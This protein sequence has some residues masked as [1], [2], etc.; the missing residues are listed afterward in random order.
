MDFAE[1]VIL[2]AR[3]KTDQLRRARPDAVAARRWLADRVRAGELPVDPAAA[4]AVKRL[5]LPD[6]AG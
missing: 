3:A 2:G 6:A 1:I 5:G 4:D